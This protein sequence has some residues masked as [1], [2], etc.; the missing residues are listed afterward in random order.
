[1]DPNI[2]KRNGLL[3]E[4]VIKGLASRNMTGYYA[5]DRTEAKRIAS[6]PVERREAALFE[7]DRELISRNLSPGGSADMLALAYLI[8]AWRTLTEV[9]V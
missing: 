4:K 2:E 1:M 5:K 9:I 6:L 3:A 8:D 7:L